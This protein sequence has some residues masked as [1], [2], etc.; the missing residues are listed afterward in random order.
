MCCDCDAQHT[1]LE[2]EDQC[3]EHRI[4]LQFTYSILHM[5]FWG[6]EVL[7]SNS[8]RTVQVILNHLYREGLFDVAE[9]LAEE[10][11]LPDDAAQEAKEKFSQMHRHLEMVWVH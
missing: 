11:G 4:L 7:G 8:L 9:A 2:T 6:H 10:A 1:D 5:S 3:R